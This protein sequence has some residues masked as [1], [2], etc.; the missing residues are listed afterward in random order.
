M[1]YRAMNH[2]PRRRMRIGGRPCRLL[3]AA[4]LALAAGAGLAGEIIQVGGKSQVRTIAEA[5]ALAGNGDTVV[6]APGD[7]YGDVAVWKQDQLTIRAGAGGRVRLIAAGSHV[8]GKGT[9]V[10][11]GGRITVEDIDFRGART[12]RRN[13]A[14]IVLES[15]HLVVRRCSFRDNE[16]GLL[17]TDGDGVLEIENSEFGENGDGSGSTHQLNV[18]SIRSL[19]VTGSYVHQARK[20][21]LLRSR[22]AENHIFYNRLTD[23]VGGESSLELDFP[24]GGLAYL[25][26]NII[27]QSAT[28]GNPAIIS[29]G[30]EGYAS[31]ASALYLASNTIIDD[32]PT[33]GVMLRVQPGV[34]QVQAINNLVVGSAKLEGGEIKDWRDKVKD[35]ARAVY[36][37]DR[38]APRPGPAIKGSFVNNINVDWTV[39]ALP[40]R[41]DYRLL[42]GSDI[43]AKFVAPDDVNGV[44]LTPKFEYVHPAAT[45]PLAAKP[46]VQGA[47]QTMA[48]A[49]RAN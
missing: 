39:L 15:G 20:G 37:Q 11:G 24:N 41:Y 2:D 23:E 29:F 36:S 27:E 10:I 48:A 28:T 49:R 34:Q 30:A 42:S 6:I 17:A 46:G 43:E 8:Q 7:Y 12:P 32:R 47:L 1:P 9:W 5:A 45:R 13:G 38:S 25:V 3:L 21:S 16:N 4:L 14:A 22:A 33:N 18:G 40:M 35:L 31:P 26:G 19:K 44:S